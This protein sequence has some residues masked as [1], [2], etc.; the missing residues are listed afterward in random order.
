MYVVTFYSFKG[1]V[2]RSMALVNVAFDLV[3]RGRRV[4]IV[5]FDLEAPGLDTFDFP[6]ATAATPGLVDYVTVYRDTG[7]APRVED[8]VSRLH[9]TEDGDGSLWLMPSGHPDDYAHRYANIDWN[10]LYE[11]HDGYLMFEDMKAQWT[12]AL[13]LDYVLIDSRTGHTDVGGICTRHLPDAV[14]VLFFPN[15]QNLRGLSRIVS[16]IKAEAEPPRKKSIN[17]HYVMSNVPD[18][19]DE[20]RILAKILDDFKNTLDLHDDPVVVHHYHSLALLNQ[21]VFTRDRPRSRLANEYGSIAAAVMRLNA[22]DRDGAIDYIRSSMTE[23][24]WAHHARDEGL[25]SWDEISRHMKKIEETHSDDGEVLYNLARWTP[26][27]ER[28]EA[29]LTRAVKAGHRSAGV[30]YER[31]SVRQRQGKKKEAAADGKRV[32]TL[33]A[34]EHMKRRALSFLSGDDLRQ[35]LRESADNVLTLD[36]Q[37]DIA[38]HRLNRSLKDLTLAYGIMQ[39]LAADSSLTT[40][41]RES[42]MAGLVLICIGCGRFAEALNIIRQQTANLE[43]MDIHTAFNYGM[44]MWACEGIIEREPFLRVV[45]CDERETDDMMGANYLQCMSIAHW[46]AGDRDKAERVAGAAIEEV[47]QQQE[48][49]FSCWCYRRVPVKEFVR[50][51]EAIL[52]MVAGNGVIPAFMAERGGRSS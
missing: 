30:Y 46:A 13:E 49:E 48:S 44:A 29:L 28:S 1:G 23:Y 26:D 22:D 39:R 8:Y 21:V 16:G 18:L 32:L 25:P 12:D 27:P 52:G 36:M 9:E 4:L 15:A 11:E 43:E 45:E 10:A 50:D 33:H 17:R 14:I 19:D 7:Q 41:Q 6:D 51:T 40:A 3:R 2:G 20:D 38:S 35:F 42:A 31:F 47:L 5:D 37:L 34:P 24:R